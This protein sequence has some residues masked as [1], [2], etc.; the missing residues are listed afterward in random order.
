MWCI[1]WWLRFEG[2]LPSVL[3]GL[4]V[5]MALSLGASVLGRLV[6]EKRPDSEDVLFSELMIWG[7]LHRW[8]TQRQLASALSMVGA[9]SEEQRAPGGR[10]SSKEQR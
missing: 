7:Y 1:V 5:G 4:L 8:R 6:W 2:I 9:M 10:L 3:V